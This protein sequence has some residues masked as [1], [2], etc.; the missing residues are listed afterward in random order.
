MRGLILP[1]G[2]QM[3]AEHVRQVAAAA[4]TTDRSA[5]L[6]TSW[7]SRAHPWPWHRHR[8]GGPITFLAERVTGQVDEQ[9]RRGL[10]VNAGQAGLQRGVRGGPGDGR[11]GTRTSRIARSTS[12]RARNQRRNP[13]MPPA[14]ALRTASA[15]SGAMRSRNRSANG[16]VRSSEVAAWLRIASWHRYS[17]AGN[18]GQ[19]HADPGITVEVPAARRLERPQ[20]L[21]RRQ[22]SCGSYPGRPGEQ[23]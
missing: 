21:L 11:G 12:W 18:R 19:Q 6:P 23:C 16:S 5:G 1:F 3:T 2:L 22:A 13:S 14:I 7:S 17:S 8:A 4:S 15:A 20:I 10:L 9:Q